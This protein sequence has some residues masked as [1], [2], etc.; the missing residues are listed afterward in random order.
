MIFSCYQAF[1]LLFCVLCK[2]LFWLINKKNALKKYL[3]CILTH[4]PFIIDN[5]DLNQL[6]YRID[7]FTPWGYNTLITS[8]GGFG[9]R[10]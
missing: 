3:F 5:L 4:V 6:S 9:H 10:G 2:Y 7:R 8:Q 1:F